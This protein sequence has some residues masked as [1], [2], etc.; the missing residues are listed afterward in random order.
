MLKQFFA[1]LFVSIV[2]SLPALAIEAPEG[3][4]IPFEGINQAYTATQFN[5]VLV[6]YV[7]DAFSRSSQTRTFFFCHR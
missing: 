5:D 2:L 6:A 4:T 3:V 7:L 1:A